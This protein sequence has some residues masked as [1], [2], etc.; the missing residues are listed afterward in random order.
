M[1][2]VIET[3]GKQYRVEV[4]TELEVELLDVEPGQAITLDRVLLVA[5]GDESSIGRP[6]GAHAPGSA[7]LLPQTPGE[8]LISFK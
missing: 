2:A 7:A 4:G 8:N 5:D 1:Y 3:G 6:R